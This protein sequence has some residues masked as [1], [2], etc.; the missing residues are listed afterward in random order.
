[1][2]VNDMLGKFNLDGDDDNYFEEKED[3]TH[4]AVPPVQHPTHNYLPTENM[5]VK[6]ECRNTW[7]YMYNQ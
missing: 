5:D 6:L 2:F 4:L 7:L 3:T 1:M